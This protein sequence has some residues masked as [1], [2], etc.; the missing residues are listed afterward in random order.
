V[1]LDPTMARFLSLS[2]SIYIL[3]LFSLAFFWCIKLFGLVDSLLLEREMGRER[4]NG[5]RG[6]KGDNR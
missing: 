5:D 4:R 6:E 1:Q 3:T 2:L